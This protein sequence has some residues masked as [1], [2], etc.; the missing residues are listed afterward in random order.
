MKN[1]VQEYFFKQLEIIEKVPI[2]EAKHNLNFGNQ[3]HDCSSKIFG[4]WLDA[5][6]FYLYQLK[7]FFTGI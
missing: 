3:R 6:Y 2:S 5:S 1:K 7:Q 4:Y